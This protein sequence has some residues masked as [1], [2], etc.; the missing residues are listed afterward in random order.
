VGAHFQL[1]ADETLERKVQ[2]AP[3]RSPM[4]T[5]DE[6]TMRPLTHRQQQILTYITYGASNKEIAHCVAISEHCVK[7]HVTRLFLRFGVANRT[8]LA[9]AAV[10]RHDPRDAPATSEAAQNVS[11]IAPGK[12]DFARLGDA[13]GTLVG[14]SPRLSADLDAVVAVGGTVRDCQVAVGARLETRAEPHRA[15]ETPL[16]G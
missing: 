14:A 6:S 7:A 8:A 11:A 1:A 4:S 16:V 13:F 9:V 15:A 3:T 10:A 2:L 5:P 12:H